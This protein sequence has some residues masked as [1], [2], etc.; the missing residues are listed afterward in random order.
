MEFLMVKGKKDVE[1]E[2]SVGL[3]MFL[4][5]MEGKFLGWWEISGN[6]QGL[7]SLKILATNAIVCLWLRLKI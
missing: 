1:E 7:E 6:A 3:E 2:D 5:V 4:W